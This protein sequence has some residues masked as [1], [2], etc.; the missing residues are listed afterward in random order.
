MATLKEILESLRAEKVVVSQPKICR[1]SAAV[2]IDKIAE[3]S[4]QQLMK[5]FVVESM[6]ITTFLDADGNPC[7]SK[8]ATTKVE[9]SKTYVPP[10]TNIV[11]DRI[12]K[13]KADVPIWEEDFADEF[14]AV[15]V[16]T[17]K[18]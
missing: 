7:E 5:G 2:D 18:I 4:Y 11:L 13:A 8:F 14:E 9:A 1:P 6:K 16:D 15:P 12:N 3:A 10:N 17:S